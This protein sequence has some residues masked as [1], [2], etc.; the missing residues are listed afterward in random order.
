[1][2]TKLAASGGRSG[3]LFVA[4][5]MSLPIVASTS[6]QNP[7]RPHVAIVMIAVL[8][9]MPFRMPKAG[10]RWYYVFAVYVVSLTA[11]YGWR[12]WG[13]MP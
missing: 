13:D 6:A 1:M 9:I 12:I 8:S 2:F 7:V 3:H 10:G 4:L 11:V 5:I